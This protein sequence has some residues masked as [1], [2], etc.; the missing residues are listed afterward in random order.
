MPLFLQQ[1]EF[2]AATGRPSPREVRREKARRRGIP[3]HLIDAELA[4]LDAL[5]AEQVAKAEGRRHRR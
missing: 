4:R 2:Q 1:P 5:H 3:E